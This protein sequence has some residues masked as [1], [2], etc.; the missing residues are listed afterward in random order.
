MKHIVYKTTNIINKKYYI[1]V[2]STEDINDEYLGCGHWRGRKIHLDTKSPILN[3]FLKYG[4]I[5]FTKDV[6]FIFESREQALSKERELVNITDRNCYN[7][8]EGGDIN[9][10]YTA[11]AKNKMS[12]SAK[13]RSRKIL[14]Q[15]NLLKEHVKNRTGKTYAEIYGEEKAKEIML[16]KSKSL[17]G[18]KL[19]D[20]HRRKMSENRKGKD[21]GQC[22]GRKNVWDIHLKRV[23]R[24]STEIVQQ[25][26]SEGTIKEENL[27]ISKFQKVKYI[28]LLLPINKIPIY[29]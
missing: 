29:S 12:K 7:A 16:K 25:G 23:V 1:G 6:L 10:T 4:D 8:R 24:L 28:K 3:A 14:L 2:H 11:E 18:R 20:E 13:I 17:T 27:T 9:Y 26:I 22:K 15:T 5:N 19:S 21:C